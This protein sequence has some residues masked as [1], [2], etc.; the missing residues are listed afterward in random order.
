MID[1]EWLESLEFDGVGGMRVHELCGEGA[2]N[3]LF[4]A[5]LPD[6]HEVVQKVRKHHLGFHIRELPLFLSDD[7]PLY[8]VG[9]VNQKLLLLLGNPL[10]DAMTCEYDRLYTSVISLLH[11]LG[12]HR[13]MLGSALDGMK[14][15]LSLRGVDSGEAIQ[16]ILG[17]QGTKRRIG[18]WAALPRD[19]KD[20]VEGLLT[21]NGPNFPFTTMRTQLIDWAGEMLDQ[22]EALPKILRPSSLEE[23]PI[24]VWGAAV[25]DGFFTDDE[26][27][28]AVDFI[29]EHFGPMRKHPKGVIFLGQAKML[30]HLL[31]NFLKDSRVDRFA[32]FCA[33]LGFDLQLSKRTWSAAD[34]EGPT[35]PLDEQPG[36][37]EP[38]EQPVHGLR[39]EVP[40]TR[41]DFGVLL[42]RAVAQMHQYGSHGDLHPG[43]FA[44]D[45]E[46]KT[47]V[48]YDFAHAK[49]LN[50]PLTPSERADD[51]LP[52]RLHSESRDWDCIW[53]GYSA[54]APNTSQEVLVLLETRIALLQPPDAS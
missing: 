2:D 5:T 21:V 54:A 3:I 32:Q 25:M 37:K 53:S 18:D 1:K 14:A 35:Q 30:A 50:R 51:L 47:V 15:S 4:R 19:Y 28:T 45:V 26:L 49:I 10:L 52:L 46:K 24:Y 27:P 43:N 36:E 41:E 7:K 34:Q 44:F 6:G 23:N 11:K 17:T 8:D 13:L 48:F 42:G 16:F 39:R 20:A 40:P 29:N 38:T 9:R 12:V 33:M 22:V 31:G